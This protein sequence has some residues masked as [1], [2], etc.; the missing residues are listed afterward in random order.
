MNMIMEDKFANMEEHLTCMED[1][2]ASLRKAGIKIMSAHTFLAFLGKLRIWMDIIWVAAWNRLK[3]LIPKHM[4][5]SKIW[6]LEQKL[7]ENNYV[8]FF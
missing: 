3:I 1:N 2:T 8:S 7:D 6:L 4:W 5:K